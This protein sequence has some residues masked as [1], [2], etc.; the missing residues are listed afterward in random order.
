MNEKAF[1]LPKES[2][3]GFSHFA[4]INEK[5]YDVYKLIELA[6]T[7]EPKIVPIELFDENKHGKHW[8]IT[9][10][11]RIGP[12]DIIDS[13]EETAGSIDWDDLLKKHPEWKEHIES[14]RDGDY[15]KYPIMYT[16]EDVIV[17]GMHRLTKAWI[18]RVEKIKT[19]WLEELPD[20]AV[21]KEPTKT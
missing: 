5:V 4:T 11:V 10:N 20:S 7:I 2:A 16:G 3:E 15:E 14:I 1:E 6:K 17:D 21:Y 8:E 12:S 9:E 19:K 13:L 18:D